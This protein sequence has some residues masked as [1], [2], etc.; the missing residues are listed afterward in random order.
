VD[1]LRKREDSGTWKRKHCGLVTMTDD[2]V[3]ECTLYT[4]CS[5]LQINC[6]HFSSTW[7]VLPAIKIFCLIN[8]FVGKGSCDIKIVRGIPRRNKVGTQCSW[9]SGRR[10]TVGNDVQICKCQAWFSWRSCPLFAERY[11]EKKKMSVRKVEPSE[12]RSLICSN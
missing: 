6:N 11:W 8:G 12:W 10:V 9:Y 4:R 7:V 2:V 3:T 5:G 1:D